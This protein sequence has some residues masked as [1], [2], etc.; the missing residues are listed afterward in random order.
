MICLTAQR[1]A[2]AEGPVQ[3]WAAPATHF[4]NKPVSTRLL[5]LW[6]C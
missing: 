3:A 6:L 5:S 4:H 1:R 2:G